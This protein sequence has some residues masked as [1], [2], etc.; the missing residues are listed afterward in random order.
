MNQITTIIPVHEFNTEIENYLT[1][2]IESVIEQEEYI[3]DVPLLIISP[4]EVEKQIKTKFG[5]INNKIE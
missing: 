5:Y 4:K 2:A 1:K 3:N